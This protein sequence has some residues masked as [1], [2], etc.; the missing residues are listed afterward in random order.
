VSGGFGHW[1]LV[2]GDGWR[3][4]WFVSVWLFYV[5]GGVGAALRRSTCGPEHIRRGEWGMKW[6][7]LFSLGSRIF[8]LAY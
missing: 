3:F 5:Q 8:I 1:G 6:R 4:E 2:G 7:V